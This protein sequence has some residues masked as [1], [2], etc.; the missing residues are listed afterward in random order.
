MQTWL[1][2]MREPLQLFSDLGF[3]GFLA[4]QLIVGGNA[5]VALVHPI[6]VFGLIWALA[7]LITQNLDTA[8][9]VQLTQYLF[10]GT[11][12]YGTSAALGWLGLHG[13][14]VARKGCVVGTPLHWILL[15]VAAWRAACELIHAPYH[16]KKTEHGVDKRFRKDRTTRALLEL[17]RHLSELEASG[18]L[19][20]IWQL[21]ISS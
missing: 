4:F 14:G 3:R 15:S 9:I 5:L 7:P 8:A 21:K 16:W 1:V 20:R 10:I 18:R 13:R 17:E 6:F 2:H 11:I 12:C 19:P